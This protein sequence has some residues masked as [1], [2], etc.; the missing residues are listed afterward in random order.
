MT[1]M[2]VV[3]HALRVGAEVLLLEFLVVV[4]LLLLGVIKLPPEDAQ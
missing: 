2:P 3:L 1:F 4:A